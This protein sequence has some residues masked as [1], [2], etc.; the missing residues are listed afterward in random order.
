MRIKV[1]SNFRELARGQEH[2]GLSSDG[3]FYVL[4]VDEENYRLINRNG[5]PILYPKDLFEVLDASIPSG[6]HFHD[7]EDGE[8]H[9]QPARTAEPGFYEDW[10][11][12]DGD[13]VAQAAARR[14]LREELER[15]ADESGKEDQVL[16]HEALSRMAWISEPRPRPTDLQ[17]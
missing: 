5:E 9:L 16:I 8:Y 12:S 13:R 6:W 7:Y 14:T 10:H 2:R 15:L 3:E 17:E 11:G 1:R 4:G